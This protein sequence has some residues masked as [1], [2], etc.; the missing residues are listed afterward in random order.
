MRCPCSILGLT[1]ALIWLAVLPATAA[2][3]PRFHIDWYETS[4][5]ILPRGRNARVDRVYEIFAK[6]L[7]A[8]GERPGKGP[9]LVVIGRTSKI[10]LYAAAIPDRSIILSEEG[11]EICYREPARGDDR[12]A[13]VL[14]H[15]ISHHKHGDFWHL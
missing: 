12:L 9:Y 6:V 15:E 8:A 10:G 13:F 1:A 11:L 7:D 5:G 2:D 14:G 4:Y 3:D